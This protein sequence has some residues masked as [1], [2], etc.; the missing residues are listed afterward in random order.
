M[1]EKP[2]PDEN[3]LLVGFMGAGKT[4]VGRLA[5]RERGLRF[6]DLDREIERVAGCPIPEIFDR[7]GEEA[8]RQM[9]TDALGHIEPDT[10]LVVS[11][12]GG[13]VSREANRALLGELGFVVWLTASE[14]EIF[15]R[16]SRN[17]SR[18]LLQAPDPRGVIRS[19][20][21]EREPLYREVADAVIDTTG[22]DFHEVASALLEAY[23]R[24]ASRGG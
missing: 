16:V 9:E 20:L 11:C 23:D 5:A 18:P 19:L 22:R 24:R 3:I 17:T 14:E 7:L 1:S 8:F 10:G 12:G 4:T 21:A 13:V 15:A 6:V 2:G